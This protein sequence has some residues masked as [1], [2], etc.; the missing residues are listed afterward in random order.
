MFYALS[1]TQIAYV[2]QTIDA[3]LDFD[4]STEISQ[5]AHT[6]FHSGSNGIL[7]VQCIP[8]IRCQL[9]HAQRNT[10]FLRIDVEN[11]AIHLIACIDELGR[12]LH[13]LRPGHFAYVNQSLDPLLQFDE[14]AVIGDA[15]YASADMRPHG[16]ALRGVQPRVGRELF[17]SEGDPLLL[18]VELENLHLNLVAHI[19][20]IP[21]M[22]EAS[23]RHVGDVEK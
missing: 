16:V 18:F 15:D 11:H 4:E 23:P 13:A 3:I 9:P 20:Q 7:A 8:R 2:N 22:R 19:Y 12:V 10:P 14:G 17:E 21:R 5:V 6:A 1:P